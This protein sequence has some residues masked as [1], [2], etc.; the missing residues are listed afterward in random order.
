VP[1]RLTLLVFAAALVAFAATSASAIIRPTQGW[2]PTMA[3][4]QRIESKVHMPDGAQAIT[5][6][7]RFYAGVVDKGRQ[8]IEGVYLARG[9]VRDMQIDHERDV[10]I[11]PEKDIPFIDDGGCL[12]VTVYY[13]V[14][15]D[16]ITHAACNGYA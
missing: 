15:S 11:S 10:Q 13:D 9:V 8:V 7:L 6:Y 16:T 2:T 14:A 4:V 5:A 12:M 3:Q 1:H